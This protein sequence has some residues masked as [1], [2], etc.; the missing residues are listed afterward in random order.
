MIQ[1]S[2]RQ[3]CARSMIMLTIAL[4]PH[5][6]QILNSINGINLLDRKRTLIEY[7]DDVSVVKNKEEEPH[8]G[9]Y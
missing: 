8:Y 7:V 4:N 5:I 6:C 2:V 1:K 3:G 9:Q